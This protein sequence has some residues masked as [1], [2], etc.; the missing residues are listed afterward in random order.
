MPTRHGSCHRPRDFGHDDQRARQNARQNA[1]HAVVRLRG[2]LSALQRRPDVGRDTVGIGRVGVDRDRADVGLAAVVVVVRPGAVDR[3]RRH[4]RA[5]RDG[6]DVGGGLPAEAV[7]S[8]VFSGFVCC[9][10]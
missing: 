1:R 6:G 3:V 10:L 7:G 8:E 5:G 4:L 2:P 9:A